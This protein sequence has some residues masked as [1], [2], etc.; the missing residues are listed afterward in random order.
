MEAILAIPLLLGGLILLFVFSILVIIFP[1]ILNIGIS[2]LIGFFCYKKIGLNKY[3]CVLIG[4][5]ISIIIGLN[6]RIPILFDTLIDTHGH[7][8]INEIIEKTDVDFLSLSSDLEEIVFLEK[9][10][11]TI[12]IGGDE[13]CM[14]FYYTYPKNNKVNIKHTFLSNDIPIS[15]RQES[16]YKVHIKNT[17]ESHHTLNLSAEIF[18]QD[19]LISS[20]KK[21]YIVSYPVSDAIDKTKNSDSISK[22]FL[23]L[24][25][26]NFWNYL[27][28]LSP[29]L[30]K[31]TNILDELIQKTFI[32]TKENRNRIN[33]VVIQA[34][35][36][37]DTP[38]EEEYSLP[39]G[40]RG[41]IINGNSNL[42][43]E[44]YKTYS[45]TVDNVTYPL[46]PEMKWH[47]VE[48]V[49]VVDDEIYFLET[50]AEQIFIE[51]YTKKGVLVQII[52]LDLPEISWAGYPRKPIIYFKKTK[53]LY[54]IGLLEF[55][56]K[57][58]PKEHY[59]HFTVPGILSSDQ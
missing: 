56:K 27:F 23:Y 48:K 42:I 4:L 59:F 6:F 18:Y 51:K 28:R 36:Y 20:L 39:V 5:L 19:R 55:G 52:K 50:R 57:I 7:V 22:F 1:S 9:P 31:Q 25:Q 53:N 54:Q 2:I 33:S 47:N 29:S 14:C 58:E 43:K 30:N 13:G 32:E 24:C 40:N 17:S 11:S 15:L 16:S 8:R 12:G 38:K 34:K 26:S 21:T 41:D 35:S 49:L 46:T 37:L 45:S 3:L 10:L 44:T